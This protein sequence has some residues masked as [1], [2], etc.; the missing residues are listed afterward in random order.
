MTL[1]TEERKLK[2]IEN[3]LRSSMAQQRVSDLSVLSIENERMCGLDDL[4]INMLIDKFAKKNA[5]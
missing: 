2:P 3:Y 1:V 5:R 4:D